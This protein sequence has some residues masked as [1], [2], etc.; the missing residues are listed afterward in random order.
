MAH[1]VILASASPFFE[2]IFRKNTHSH[3]LIYIRGMNSVELEQALDFMYFGEVS[4]AEEQ[5]EAFL[6]L[7]E[8]FQL[9]AF[10]SS[11]DQDTMG[12]CS[13]RKLTQYA[14]TEVAGKHFEKGKVKVGNYFEKV[15]VCKSSEKVNVDKSSENVKA[16]KS[17]EKVKV[18]K[19]SEKVENSPPELITLK[20]EL[21]VATS[22]VARKTK[23]VTKRI[24]SSFLIFP[25]E[26]RDDFIIFSPEQGDDGPHC[27][28]HGGKVKSEERLSF[29]DEGN[30]RLE[31]ANRQ[32]SFFVIRKLATSRM[33]L[34]ISNLIWVIGRFVVT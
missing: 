10:K 24:F 6:T 17:S 25:P 31:K 13:K 23:E 7:A 29:A 19:S 33:S 26:Q 27:R 5:L 4:I 2:A 12:Q 18:Y 20:T 8:D 1:R 14:T 34:N 3:P 11:T 32:V 15:K 16:D 22:Q 28:A 30:D 9:N 21:Q